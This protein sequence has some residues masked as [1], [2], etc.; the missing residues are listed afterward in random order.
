MFYNDK[1]LERSFIFF[2]LIQGRAPSL[3]YTIIE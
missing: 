3:S 1:I 2:E